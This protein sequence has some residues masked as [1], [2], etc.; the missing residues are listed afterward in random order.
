M[1]TSCVVVLRYCERPIEVNFAI[2][3]PREGWDSIPVAGVNLLMRSEAGHIVVD[4][5]AIST[6]RSWARVYCPIIGAET[7]WEFDLGPETA[8]VPDRFVSYAFGGLRLA[9]R[10]FPPKVREVG[11]AE[12]LHWDPV[13]RGA[14]HVGTLDP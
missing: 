7:D 9:W 5:G 8:L 10:A 4:S 3:P 11:A 1:A 14:R 12:H 6:G 2:G 13:G